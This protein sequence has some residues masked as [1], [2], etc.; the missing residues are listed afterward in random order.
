[1][2]LSFLLLAMAVMVYAQEGEE[3]KSNKPEILWNVQ[4]EYDE[5]GNIIR[6]DSSYSF[7]YSS[8]GLSNNF[9]DS[10]RQYFDFSFPDF[11][12]DD[13][14]MISPFD[15]FPF[16]EPLPPSGR[17]PHSDTESDSLFSEFFHLHPFEHFFEDPF[18]D[19]F[20]ND[21]FFKEDSI[22]FNLHADPFFSPFIP[23]PRDMFRKQHE[24]MEKF[25]EWHNVPPDSL[26]F[27]RQYWNAPPARKKSLKELEI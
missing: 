25:F 12:G 8:P 3:E 27:D 2:G 1:M 16:D 20:F 5:N 19:Q 13:P 7:Y 15:Q 23:D 18:F 26:D 14:F 21:E 6:Y 9:P 24:L 10:I 17:F 22:A 4:K 11:S